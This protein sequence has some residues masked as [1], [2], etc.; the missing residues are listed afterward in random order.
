MSLGDTMN[1]YK[2]LYFHLF[3]ALTD[4]LRALERGHVITAIHLLQRAQQQA[5]EWVMEFDILPDT[6]MEQ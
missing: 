3:N 5:E 2:T 1:S 6:P 4:A